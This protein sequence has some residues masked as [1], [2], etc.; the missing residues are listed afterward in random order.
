MHLFGINGR[1]VG[2]QGNNYW[3][4]VVLVTLN[5]MRSECVRLICSI[6]RERTIHVL[7][8][9]KITK[10]APILNSGR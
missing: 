4:N 10:L 6:D 3:P 7:H 8:F 2:R 1:K 5:F 9:V